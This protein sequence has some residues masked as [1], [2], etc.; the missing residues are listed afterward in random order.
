ML[1]ST[2]LSFM[3]LMDLEGSDHQIFFDVQLY[4]V[5]QIVKSLSFSF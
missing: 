5:S 2:F 4:F 1:S 3:D